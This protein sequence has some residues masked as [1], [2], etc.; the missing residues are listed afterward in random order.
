MWHAPA[1]KPHNLIVAALNAAVL[2]ETNPENC[3]RGPR[4]HVP[5]LSPA[6]PIPRAAE[7]H[8]LVG[9]P[10]TRAPVSLPARPP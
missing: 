2:V 4:D 5:H 10:P 6:H 9:P 3:G 1:Q 8:V 7:G